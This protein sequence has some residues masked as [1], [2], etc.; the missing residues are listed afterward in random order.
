MTTP[1]ATKAGRKLVL[2]GNTVGGEVGTFYV[3]F[4]IWN[5]DD[6]VSRTLN[7]LVD[8]GST[9][10]VVPETILDELEIERR[11]YMRFGLADGSRRDLAIGRV[12]ME[13]T[14]QVEIVPV[15]FGPDPGRILIG[16]ITL[17]A[18]ALAAEVAHQRLIPADLTL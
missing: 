3:D 13:L 11:R 10:S 9:Y 18:F 15:V 12:Q 7:G 16:A 1:K 2:P 5:R 6:T 8:T 17:E 14:D 4:V